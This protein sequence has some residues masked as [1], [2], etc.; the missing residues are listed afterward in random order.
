M[1]AKPVSPEETSYGSSDD[2][3]NTPLGHGEEPVATGTLFFVIIILMI[4]GAV[5][6]IMYLRLLD[7]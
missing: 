7:R 3:F 1:N 2:Y 5:W 4:I 6:L